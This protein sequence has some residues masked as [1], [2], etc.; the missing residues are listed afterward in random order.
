MRSETRISECPSA[1]A[2]VSS[3]DE[4]EPSRVHEVAADI[5]SE[6]AKVG[7]HNSLAESEKVWQRRWAIA[8]VT[9]DGPARDQTYL[10]FK[11]V[12]YAADGAVSYGQDQCAGARIPLT[13]IM[14]CI[15]GT[16]KPSCCRTTACIPRWQESTE[17]PLSHL[18]GARL[19]ARRLKSP[20]ACFPWMTDS[21]DG[22]EQAPWSIGDYVWHQNAD[23]AYAIDQYVQATGTT[24]SCE[25][26]DWRYSW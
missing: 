12:Q 10:R 21:Q 13:G 17:L 1:V 25:T 23:I 16:V 7:Y 9:I 4:V 22:T 18:E 5:A 26:K 19:N 20:G 11:L 14:G 15:I 6:A 2:V 3:R 24:S 8:D